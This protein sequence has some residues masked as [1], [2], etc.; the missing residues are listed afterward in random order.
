[1]QKYDGD[2]DV[3]F[4]IHLNEDLSIKKYYDESRERTKLTS[5]KVDRLLEYYEKYG[6]PK[7]RE[8]NIAEEKLNAL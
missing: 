2:L 7:E 3:A 6:V 5:E 1:M 4:H 8:K